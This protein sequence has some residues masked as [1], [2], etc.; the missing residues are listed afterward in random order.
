MKVLGPFVVTCTAAPSTSDTLNFGYAAKGFTVLGVGVYATDMDTNG[1]PTLTIN[2]GDSGSAARLVSAT[3]IAQT[4]AASFTSLVAST[5]FAYQ[6]TAKTLITGVA[7]NNAATGAAG[8]IT[9]Y[10]YGIQA[11]STTS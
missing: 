4:G 7:A 2:I 8:T 10:V 3:T 11:D 9:L 1:T 5:G 6:Y